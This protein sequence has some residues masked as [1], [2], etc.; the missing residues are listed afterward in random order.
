MSLIS[1][2]SSSITLSAASIG[3]KICV[4]DVGGTH[5]K[6]YSGEQENVKMFESG[7]E[8]TPAAFVAGIH[9]CVDMAQFEGVSIGFPSPVKGHRILKEPANLGKGWVNVDFGQVLSCPVKLINDAAMQAVGSYEGGSMLFLGLGTGLGSALV[10]D[11]QLQPMELAHLPFRDKDYEYYVSEQH[12]ENVGDVQW[13]NDV[14]EIANIFYNTFMPD[15]IV[16]GGGNVH[17]L[18]ELPAHIRRGDNDKAFLGGIR[19]WGNN[20]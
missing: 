1:G 14:F 7:H 17:N 19:L 2:T 4:I 12:R 3:K 20:L 6:I 5:V 15:Y 9:Q 10:V 8:M 16:L 13:H 11:N 18:R